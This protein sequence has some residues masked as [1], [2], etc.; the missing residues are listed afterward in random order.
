MVYVTAFFDIA[1]HN[2][3]TLPQYT[4]D[5]IGFIRKSNPVLTNF[6]QHLKSFISLSFKHKLPENIL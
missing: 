5:F 4:F 3:A 1:L 6:L 2:F